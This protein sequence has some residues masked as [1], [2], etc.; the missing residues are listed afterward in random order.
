MIMVS[1]SSFCIASFSG[2]A[3][4]LVTHSTKIDGKLNEGMGMKQVFAF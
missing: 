1:S 3:Q 2:P 4:L